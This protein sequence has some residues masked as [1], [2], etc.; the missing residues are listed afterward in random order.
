MIVKLKGNKTKGHI[1]D[2]RISRLLINLVIS[3]EQKY[4]VCLKM[5]SFV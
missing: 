3:R 1:N 5:V 2:K 4:L